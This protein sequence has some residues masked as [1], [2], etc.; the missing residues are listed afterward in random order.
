MNLCLEYSY[1]S[2]VQR[3]EAWYGKELIELAFIPQRDKVAES[4]RL[5]L[6]KVLKEPEDVLFEVEIKVSL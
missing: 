1:I 3:I 5:E 2:E 4:I 6:E